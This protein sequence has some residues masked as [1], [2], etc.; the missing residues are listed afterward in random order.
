V[1]GELFRRK[2]LREIA[3]SHALPPRERAMLLRLLGKLVADRPGSPP[4]P[5]ERSPERSSGPGRVASTASR[6]SWT[7]AR[8]IRE[9]VAKLQTTDRAGC[10][11]AHAGTWPM[12]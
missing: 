4:T 6:A 2:D 12:T 7:A 11:C 5:S 9:P 8:V 10:E 1:A 3:W